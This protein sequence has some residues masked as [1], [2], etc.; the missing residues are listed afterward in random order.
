VLLGVAAVAGLLLFTGVQAGPAA[1]HWNWANVAL[2]QAQF[3]ATPAVA[4][5]WS[6]AAIADYQ[7]APDASAAPERLH[8]AYQMRW[9]A[10]SQSDQRNHWREAA[11]AYG[12][13]HGLPPAGA[14]A[15]DCPVPTGGI[16]QAE[17]FAG[18]QTGSLNTPTEIAGTPAVLLFSSA[19]ISQ[20]V[21]LEAAGMYT[22]TVTAANLL[23]PPVAVM[24]AW[25]GWPAG[26][27]EYARGDDSLSPA[28]VQ[29][30]TPAGAHTLALTFANDFADP[31]AGID[32]NAIIDQVSITRGATLDEHTH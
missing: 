21:C 31:A 6:G 14:T 32:R 12:A 17:D 13:G 24:V 5:D 18:V 28:A 27:L 26:V 19:P 23:P 20:S 10:G 11:A 30:V 29:V 8:S 9:R 3:A 16:L 22:I 25:D 7:A 2:M 1:W 4:F 15:A